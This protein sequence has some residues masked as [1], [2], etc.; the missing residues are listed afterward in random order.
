VSPIPTIGGREEDDEERE[1]REFWGGD[2]NGNILPTSG[3]E[4]DDDESEDDRS[5]SEDGEGA[6]IDEDEDDEDDIQLFGH[7]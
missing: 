4:T 7:R 2:A 3:G 6:D 1:A 5:D